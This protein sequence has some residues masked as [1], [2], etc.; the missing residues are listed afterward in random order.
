MLDHENAIWE[1]LLAHLRSTIPQLEF[2][3]WFN[4]VK[5]VGIQDGEFVIGVAGNFARDWIRNNYLSH[6]EAGLKQLGMEAP[7]VGFQVL[8]LEATHQ[9]DMFSL[10]ESE[11]DSPAAAPT[12]TR[13]NSKYRFESFVVGSNNNL[14]YAAAQAITERP[15]QTYNP[16]FLYGDAGLGKTH[17]MHAVGHEVAARFP[18]LSIEYVTTEAFT[19]DLINA[20]R[21]KDTNS[22]RERYRSVD[23]LL[24]DDVQFIAGKEQTQEEFF[25][26]F[27][28]LYEAGKQIILSSDRPPKNIPTLENRLRSRFEWGL[29]TDIQPPE[30]ETRVA[31]LEQNAQFRNVKLPTDV[32][33]YIARQVTSNIRELEGALVRVI[34]HVSM[35]GGALTVEA[36]ANALSDVFSTNEVVLNMD[37]ILRKVGKIFN[38][39]VKDLRSKGRRQELVLPRQLA[40]YLIREHTQHSF[41]EIGQ[42]FSGR[43][44]STVMYS[45]NKVTEQLSEDA[46]LQR[47]LREVRHSL[48]LS[49]QQ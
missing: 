19:N 23:L 7:R 18:S 3:T 15:G 24:V 26:T 39:D 16:L 8:P 4:Q 49:A 28:S 5:P 38:I 43:D 29:I 35:N 48:G 21:G 1:E 27:N 22:F 31:I 9:Q 20:I 17:L 36:A 12:R 32:A 6:I 25:H 37:E 2:T 10:A 47:K 44:H 42:F 46:D 45:I 40:M 13:L 11:D 34:V 41:P 14:A 33:E 30:F